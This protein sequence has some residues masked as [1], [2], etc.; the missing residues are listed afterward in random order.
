[1][2]FQYKKF[3]FHGP[4]RK[5]TR[6]HENF[7]WETEQ[8]NAFKTLKEALVSAEV[9]SYY[10][11]NAETRLIIDASPV[12]LGAILEQKQNGNFRPVAYASRTLNAVERRYSQIER[13]TLGVTWSIERFHGYLYGINFTVLKRP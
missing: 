1:M 10:D 12:G 6:K 3:I 4:L 8:E 9:M 2:C 11:P 7:R 13:E 5:L